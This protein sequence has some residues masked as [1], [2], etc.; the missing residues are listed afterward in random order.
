MNKASIII[1]TLNG[2]QKHLKEAVDSCI[3]QDG[4]KI[5]LIVSTVKKDPCLITLKNYNIDFVI[6]DRPGIYYQLNN[7]T[8]K[9]KNDW[10]CYISGNDVMDPKK[11]STEIYICKKKGKKICYSDYNVCDENMKFL[12]KKEFHKYSFE[13]NL[14]G[15]FIHDGALIHRSISDKYL[16]FIEKFDNLGYWNFWLRVGRDNPD[17]FLYNKHIAFNYRLSNSSRHVKR[18]YNKAWKRQ[19]F[20]DRVNMLSGFG[21]LRGKY[22]KKYK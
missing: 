18:K 17:A 6:N 15:N 22:A 8:K 20:L 11:I 4:C 7:A 3:G 14:E 9:I 19:E 16:P 10:W 13:K 5:Q 1:N 12:Y 21:K 2:N